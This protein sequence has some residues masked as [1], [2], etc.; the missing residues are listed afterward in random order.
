MINKKFLVICL[1]LLI[2]FNY[3]IVF[4]KVVGENSYKLCLND[5]CK[6][7][8]EYPP[9]HKSYIEFDYSF[10][11]SKCESNK[12]CAECIDNCMNELIKNSPEI[13]KKIRDIEVISNTPT[14]C[15]VDSI[16]E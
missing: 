11:K 15:F 13:A 2:L 12:M 8:L 3:K 16:N 5:C 6:E 10:Y 14:N 9:E 4:S 7:C 1:M